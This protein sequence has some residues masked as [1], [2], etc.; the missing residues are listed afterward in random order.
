MANT[1]INTARTGGGGVPSAQSDSVVIDFDDFDSLEVISDSEFHQSR[2]SPTSKSP[3]IPPLIEDDDSP[4]SA[5]E[6]DEEVNVAEQ[7]RNKMRDNL[8]DA[9]W[10]S[11]RDK[12]TAAFN[13]YAKIDILRP[14]FDV[15]PIQVRNRLLASFVPV[16]PTAKKQPSIPGDLYGP[17]MVIFTL[18]AILLFQMKVSS[19]RVE[20]GTLMGTAFGLCFTYWFGAS[21]LLLGLAYFCNIQLRLLQI[22]SLLGYAMFSH[23]LVLLLSTVIHTHHSHLFFYFLW[24]V[25]GGLSALRLVAVFVGRTR[26]PRN[27]VFAAASV[28]FLHLVF[29][30]YLHFAYHENV[31]D[32]EETFEG[33]KG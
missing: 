5:I 20:D 26:D 32:L 29:M 13:M 10:Q 33:I 3:F 30:L 16:L 11:G 31:I 19:H 14:Y 25:F 12:A 1:A 7:L 27:R 9:L 8:T 24:L 17:C 28:A 6:T 4:A 21:G 22:L 18:I 23:C 15:E 2:D